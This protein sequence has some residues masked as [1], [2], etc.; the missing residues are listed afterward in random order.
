MYILF[1]RYQT[2][3]PFHR[4]SPEDPQ[5]FGNDQRKT[6]NIQYIRRE[7]DANQFFG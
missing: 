2:K 7:H 4:S 6:P 5:H 1:N 3:N